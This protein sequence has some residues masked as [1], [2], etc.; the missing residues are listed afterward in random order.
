MLS[1]GAPIDN[2]PHLLLSTTLSSL[3]ASCCGDTTARVWRSKDPVR[4]R[5]IV[6]RHDETVNKTGAAKGVVWVWDAEIGVLRE[7]E[8]VNSLEQ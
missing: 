8:Q 5:P 1:V 6:L 2:I 4:S 7:S 3:I